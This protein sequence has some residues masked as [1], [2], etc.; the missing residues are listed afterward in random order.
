MSWCHW[1]PQNSL[2]VQGNFRE[3]MTPEMR[4]GD[5]KSDT[6]ILLPSDRWKKCDIWGKHV[7]CGCKGRVSWGVEEQKLKRWAVA[8]WSWPSPTH[9][10]DLMPLKVHSPACAM[11]RLGLRKHSAHT[12]NKWCLG[13]AS[14]W[15]WECGVWGLK[16]MGALQTIAFGMD[17][18]RN[19][20]V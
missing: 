16:R 1:S 12:K 7:Q 14:H 4:E 20:A 17:K 18:Q 15:C 3:N 9:Q 2:G 8:D 5:G 10:A 6:E 11:V 19:P 13:F